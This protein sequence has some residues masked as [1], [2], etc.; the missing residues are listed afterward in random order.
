MHINILQYLHLD[1]RADL[2]HN[3]HD[4]IIYFSYYDYVFSLKMACIAVTCC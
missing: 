4:I 1:L 3:I 2:V